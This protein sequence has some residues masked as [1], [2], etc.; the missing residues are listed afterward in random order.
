MSVFDAS[1]TS[2]RAPESSLPIS[3]PRLLL[4]SAGA[5]ASVSLLGLSPLARSEEPKTLPDYVRWKNANDVIVHS[6]NTIETERGA[7]GSGV[8]TNS[9]KLYVRNNL[10]APNADI[11]ADRNAWKITLEGGNSP[12]T[13]TLGELKKMGVET[14]TTVLQC[15]GNGRAYFE[16]GPGGTQWGT[17][18]A[19]C[20]VWTGVPLRDVVARLGGVKPD[21]N[22]ITSTG[23]ETLPAGLDP[24]TIMVERSVPVRALDQA[25]LAW[26]MNDEPVPLAH[27]GPLRMVFPGYFGVNNVKYV[28]RV[29]FTEGQ[30]DAKI[31]ASGYRI[32]PIG[33]KGAPGQP[34]MWE[35][36]VKSWVTAPLTTASKGRNLIYGVAFGG[37]N[38]VNQVEVSADGGETWKSARFLGPDMGRYAWRPF[39][40][41]MD[42]SAGDHRIVSRATDTEGNTQPP[43]STENERGYGNA[44]WKDHGV[45]VTVS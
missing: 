24:K 4:G 30:S 18:A 26:Q 39:V 9:D 21:M 40:V 38:A 6:A 45:T 17:G 43:T 7:I 22:Y 42:L 36:P 33:E 27:G 5:M 14:V 13:L 29:A 32:R 31:Q 20:L 35:M 15:S 1:S 44:S 28:D 10:P 41:A 8:V 2:R 25:L 3:R 16:H 12:Q 19:G 34:S 37:I 11:V 23:G